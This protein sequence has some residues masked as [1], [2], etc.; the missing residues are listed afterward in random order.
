M[1]TLNAFSIDIQIEIGIPDRHRDELVRHGTL[2][3][4]V[5][6][7]SCLGWSDRQLPLPLTEIGDVFLAIETDEHTDHVNVLVVGAGRDAEAERDMT[8]AGVDSTVWL[9]LTL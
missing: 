5:P 4:D 8:P 6:Q 2:Q 1:D 9:W 7:L 3:M